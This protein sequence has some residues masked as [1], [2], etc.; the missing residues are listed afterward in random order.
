MLTPCSSEARI[1]FQQHPCVRGREGFDCETSSL[2]NTT[3]PDGGTEIL[4]EVHTP[5]S[6][7]LNQKGGFSCDCHNQ[8]L[9]RV[10]VQTY[11]VW[12]VGSACRI[13][14]AVVCM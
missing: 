7:N 8:G 11:N 1:L 5:S 12:C 9:L 6:L 14:I 10:P 3:D 13:R 2:R 4:Q